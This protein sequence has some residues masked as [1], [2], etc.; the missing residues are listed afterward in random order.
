MALCEK[1]SFS[2]TQ[3]NEHYVVIDQH[4]TARIARLNS[5]VARLYLVDVADVQQHIPQHITLTD[6]T[7][8]NVPPFLNN[9]LITWTSS[10]TLWVHGREHMVL[11]NQKQ[12]S[13]RG[14]AEA[15]SGIV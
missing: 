6:E 13:I 14:V 4:L 11:N 9:F 3:D 15:A 7:G 1:G 10:Y 2:Y 8:S 12:Q 5:N